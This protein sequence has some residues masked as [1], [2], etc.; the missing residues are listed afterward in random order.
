MKTKNRIFSVAVVGSV[1]SMLVL[2]GCETPTGQGAGYGAATGAIIGGIA[3]GD[4]RS[5]A[6]GGAIGAGA[7]ALLGHLIGAE[8]RRKQYGAP[9]RDG[10]PVGTPTDRRGYVRSPY[11]PNNLIDVR[12]IPSGSHV[13]DPSTDRIFI[14]P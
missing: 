14:V 2:T 7:G 1:A 11:P 5:A 9:P 4:V 8:Q 13:V 12:G 10:Y 6:T 3:G